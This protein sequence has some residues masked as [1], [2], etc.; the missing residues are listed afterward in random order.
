[1]LTAIVAV[2][3]TSKSKDGIRTRLIALIATVHGLSKK[4][5]AS[6]ES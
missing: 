3:K 4:P 5:A 1:M 2:I 6:A